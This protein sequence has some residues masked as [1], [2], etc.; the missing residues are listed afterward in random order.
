MN[1]LTRMI[2]NGVTVKVGRALLKTNKHSPTILFG[3]GVVGVVATAVA[4][5]S[6]T[7]K[8]EPVLEK[9]AT[10]LNRAK[11]AKEL[12]V[13]TYSDEDYTRDVALVYTKTAIG[14]VK[15]YAPALGLGVITICALTSSHKMLTRRNAALTAAYAALDRGFR[16]YR[17]RVE[18]EFGSEAERSFRYGSRAEFVTEEDKDKPP[19]ERAVKHIHSGN[20][21]SIYAR[22][23]DEYSRRWSKTPEYNLVF[24]RCQQNYANDLLQSRGHVF[25]NEVYDSL[26][27]E[28]SKAGAVVGWVIN[29][30]GDNF[31]DFGIFDGNNFKARDFVNGNEPSILLDFNV[32][33]V[34]YDKI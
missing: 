20:T 28:R 12:D 4:A 22:F 30:E 34:I 14:I 25:L 31:V 2:P 26:G 1:Q 6:A 15:L 3:V 13:P 7:L 10:D 33:G 21:P 19:T 11:Q 9:A 16:E 32:D 27:I 5:S 18:D 29:K 17:A 24:L 8:L 23:F